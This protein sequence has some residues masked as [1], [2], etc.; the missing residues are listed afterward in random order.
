MIPCTLSPKYTKLL[1][2]GRKQDGSY[3]WGEEKPEESR[4]G[5]CHGN[6]STGKCI[7]SSGCQLQ[8]YM[9]AW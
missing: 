4:R 6:V 8:R 1:Y 7:S 2:V 3:L 9:V 5:V